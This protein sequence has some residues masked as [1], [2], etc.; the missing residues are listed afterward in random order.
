MARKRTRA[1]REAVE[2]GSG[3]IARILKRADIFRFGKGRSPN[4]PGT[5]GRTDYPNSIDA[6]RATL[7]QR[8]REKYDRIMDKNGPEYQT[9]RERGPV[10]SG[11]MD[12]KTGKVYFGQNHADPPGDLHPS[13][14]SRVD[15]RNDDI[16]NGRVPTPEF[17]GKP[18]SHSEVY[19]WNE[20]LKDRPDAKPE[21]L[22]VDNIRLKGSKKGEFIECCAN[23]S[24]IVEG[25][26]GWD[27]K[28]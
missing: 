28:N 10:L 21:D 1:N 2:A 6:D 4:T 22:I 26:D 18:G 20:V 13:I 24:S 3:L 25:I 5:P 14:K 15:A 8:L 17:L 19:A 11:I 16:A 23:C 27:R 9:N 7:N 12:R